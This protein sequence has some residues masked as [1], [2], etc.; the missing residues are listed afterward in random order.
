M[1]LAD[2]AR[3]GVD[4]ALREAHEEVGLPASAVEVIGRLPDYT[5]VTGF[6][7]TPVVA[8]VQPGFVLQPNPT[9]VADV[10]EV[11]LAFLMDPA[12]HR[13]HQADL[14]VQV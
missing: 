9:E 7:V 8:L 6:V 4:A 1:Q 3:G 14:G 12:N 2:L 11:P 5:T 13:R 10:F